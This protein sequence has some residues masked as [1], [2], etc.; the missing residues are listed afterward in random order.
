MKPRKR[1]TFSP[2]V[3]SFSG[4]QWWEQTARFVWIQLA[5]Q[6]KPIRLPRSKLPTFPSAYELADAAALRA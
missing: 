3:V 4:V 5:T 2:L 1:E 6:A